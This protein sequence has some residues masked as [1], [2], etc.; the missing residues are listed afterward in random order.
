MKH[1]NGERGGTSLVDVT[2]EA[3]E[4]GEQTKEPFEHIQHFFSGK[5]PPEQ[6]SNGIVLSG[7]IFFLI[8]PHLFDAS[9]AVLERQSIF[10]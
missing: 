3:V 5:V 7:R 10:G 4:L 2:S 9:D 6:L 1:I 8:L